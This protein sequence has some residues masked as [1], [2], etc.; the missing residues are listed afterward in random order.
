VSLRYGRATRE[1]TTRE[2][3]AKEAGPVL[4]RYLAIATKTRAQFK[5]TQDAPVE[6]FI[7]EADRHPVFELIAQASGAP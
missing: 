2:A 7:A 5:A 4:K 3:S 1:Y 6:D